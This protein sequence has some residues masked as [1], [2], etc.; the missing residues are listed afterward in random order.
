MKRFSIKDLPIRYSNEYN[1]KQMTLSNLKNWKELGCLD[2]EKS[3]SM[4]KN[5]NEIDTFFI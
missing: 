3:I 2:N 1:C 5:T 4:I